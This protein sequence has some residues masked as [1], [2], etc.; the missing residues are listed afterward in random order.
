MSKKFTIDTIKDLKIKIRE[1]ED[2]ITSI[3]Q[4]NKFTPAGKLNLVSEDCDIEDFDSGL[5]N[6]MIKALIENETE[7]EAGKLLFESIRLTPLQASDIGYWSYQNHYVFHRYIAKRWGAIWD[8]SKNVASKSQH[9]INHWIQSNSTQGE[10]IDYPVSGLWWSF[11]LTVDEEREDKYEL[12]KVFFKNLSL[13]TKYF[14]QAR[15]ARHRP[16]LFGALEFIIENKLD[17]GSLEEA[18]RAIYPYLNLLGGIRPLTYLDKQWFK[19][20]LDLRFAKQI[21]AGQKLFVRPDSKK[22]F[23]VFETIISGRGSERIEVQGGYFFNLDT[24]SGEYALSRYYK[25]DWDYSI[26]IIKDFEN[27]Y[28]IHFYQ[29]GKIKKT[30]IQGGIS[31]K[32]IDRKKPYSNG[33]CMTQT[34]LDCQVVTEPVLFGIAYKIGRRVLFKAMD[35]QNVDNFRIDNTGLNQE[36]KKV[37][38]TEEDFQS[39][40]K[41]LPYSIKGGLGSLVLTSPSAKGYDITSKHFSKQWKVLEAHWPELFDDEIDW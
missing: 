7:F 35:E 26:D 15:F 27:Q 41:I 31:E 29:E 8:S 32:M 5:E 11:Y 12:T 25:S 2:D 24:D 33:K 21:A 13:R 18:A 37:I 16:A 40:Y 23:D 6:L 30:K 34:L 28:L 14:G 4:V 10:L 22:E 36:G 1:L 39:A 38:Y 20:K 17:D 19:E 3:Y 9:I